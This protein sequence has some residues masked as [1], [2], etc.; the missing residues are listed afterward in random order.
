MLL[1]DVCLRQLLFLFIF[2]VFRFSKYLSPQYQKV[3]ATVICRLLAFQLWCSHWN[4]LVPVI[5]LN[6]FLFL[7]FVPLNILLNKII[8]FFILFQ[9]VNQILMADSASET[10]FLKDFKIPDY[11][12][13]PEPNDGFHHETPKYPVIIFINSKSGGQLGGDLLHTYRSILNK[14]QVYLYLPT[15]L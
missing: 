10:S 11:I 7:F 12:L 15:F 3:K 6:K 8:H 2:L 1:L 4:Y 13:A 14:N 9:K 5:Y